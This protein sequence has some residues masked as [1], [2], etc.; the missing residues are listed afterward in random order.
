MWAKCVAVA[1]L[2]VS[3]VAADPAQER[4]VKIVTQ[5]QKADYEGDRAALKRLAGE[6]SPFI[7]NQK[8]VAR[9]RYWRGFA[10]WR[11]AINGFNDKTDPKELQ[12]DL[13]LALDEFDAV[14][15]TDASFADAKIEA[16]SCVGL[17]AFS[18]GR[19]EP[20]RVQALMARGMQMKKEADAAEPVNPRMQWV[21]GPMLWNTPAERGGGQAKAMEAYQK[22][23]DAIR[24]Q[25][26]APSDP[27]EPR[28][29]E[30]ELLMSLAWSNLNRSTPDVNAA[31]Q[32]AAWALE[33]VTYWHYVRDILMVQIRE[34]KGKEK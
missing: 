29:G 21:M 26:T 34:A 22:G 19:Q 32:Y 28:W 27:L 5:I 33:L 7:E 24:K 4:A 25:K 9:V 2:F 13:Q 12:E 6:L 10:L 20:E 30:P 8:L 16:L 17:L 18:V 3:M 11:R 15:G 14:S 1:S 23:L 31:E